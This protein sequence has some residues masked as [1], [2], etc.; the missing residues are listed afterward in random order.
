MDRKLSK[1]VK[2]I[3]KNR[4]QKNK[5]KEDTMASSMIH[6]A[7]VQ[8][9]RKK[10]S[11]RDINRL[12]LGVILPD[13]AV[14][15]NSHLKKKICENTRYTYDLEFFRDRY[16]K[17][18]KKDDLYLGYYLH[19]IQDMLY[20]RVMYGEH[21]WNSSVP[22]NVEKLH[23]DYEILNEYVSKKY[24]LSQEMIQELDLTKEPLAQLA[25][26]DVKG[27]IKEV[28]R[29]FTQRKK[30]KLFI[31]TRQMAD[32]YIVRATEFCVEELK[33]LSKGKSGLD[34]TVWSWE[35]PENISHEK[36]NQ[37]LNAKIENM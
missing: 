29:E 26:F 16:V 31:L 8:E 4:M 21:V 35:K 25:E 13:G 17:Y 34:S 11:F 36:L 23:R 2:L 37:K 5:G 18:M 19:L 20:R 28:R 15:G 32:E 14:A 10:V 22:G 24:S 33:A 12:F 6:L 27:L 7:I 30:E 9:M 3:L 1:D